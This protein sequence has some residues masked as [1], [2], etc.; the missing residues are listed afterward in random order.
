VSEAESGSGSSW[1]RPSWWGVI[2]DFATS[3][4]EFIRSR[5]VALLLGALLGIV[6]DIAS[7]IDAALVSI[8]R[9]IVSVGDALAMPGLA[10]ALLNLTSTIPAT[11]EEIAASA[12]PASPV[13][14]I[15]LTAALIVAL[16]W[17]ARIVLIALTEVSGSIPIVGGVISAGLATLR[18]IIP[19][20][21]NNG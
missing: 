13:V 8:Q 19:G 5:V 7:A 1:A 15:A 14:A 20:A 12:G 3:P 18:R 17:A 6:T 16:V 11:I 4:T 9:A 21:D 2:R 10:D